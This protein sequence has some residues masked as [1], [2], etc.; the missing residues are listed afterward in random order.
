MEGGKAADPSTSIGAVN[1]LFFHHPLLPLSVS[2]PPSVALRPAA[3]GCKLAVVTSASS[4]TVDVDMLIASTLEA[5]PQ[6]VHEWDLLR[7]EPRLSAHQCYLR[8]IIIIIIVCGAHPHQPRNAPRAYE[9]IASASSS[10]S[11]SQAALAGGQIHTIIGRKN[12]R[13]INRTGG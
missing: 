2:Y 7:V 8:I 1:I 11:S 5:L 10:A 9:P 6:A 13:R 12:S 3:G 4:Y